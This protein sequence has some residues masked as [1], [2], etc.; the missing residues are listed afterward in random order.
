MK[1]LKRILNIYKIQAVV[2]IAFIAAVVLTGIISVIAKTNG[3][4]SGSKS[5]F[6]ET[7]DF[8]YYKKYNQ[9]YNLDGYI[10]TLKYGIYSEN[11]MS[12]KCFFEVVKENGVMEKPFFVYGNELGHFGNN[13]SV[14][15]NGTGTKE[16]DVFGKGDIAGSYS[17]RYLGFFGKNKKYFY[18]YRFKNIYDTSNIKQVYVNGTKI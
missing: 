2:M 14:A 15:L 17:Q 11:T 3:N 6:T 4:P 16:N 9:S 5:I 10:I 13:I 12:G 7:K 18:A 1:G 8:S